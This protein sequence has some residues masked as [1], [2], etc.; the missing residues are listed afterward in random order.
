MARVGLRIVQWNGTQVMNALDGKL[1]RNMRP[2]VALLEREVKTSMKGGGIPHVP[3][4]AGE[5]PRIDTG[6]YRARIYSEISVS[7]RRVSGRVISPS[8]QARAL[9]FGYAPGNLSPRPHLRPALQRRR[10]DI[11][12]VLIGS[13]RKGPATLFEIKGALALGGGIN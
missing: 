8:P 1:A 4:L 2:A 3:S 12:R 7:L 11:Y 9:E 10:I 6:V 5:T 13:V